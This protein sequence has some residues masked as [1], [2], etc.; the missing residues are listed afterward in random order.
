M[1][2][3]NLLNLSLC[4]KKYFINSLRVLYNTTYFDHFTPTPS[5][6]VSH[7]LPSLLYVPLAF[8]QYL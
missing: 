8:V 4:L 7:T 2:N 1:S 5:R 3:Y 6:P